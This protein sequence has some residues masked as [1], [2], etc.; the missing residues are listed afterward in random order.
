MQLKP[1]TGSEMF[2]LHLVPS[3]VNFILWKQGTLRFWVLQTLNY[4]VTSIMSFFVCYL[5]NANC[6]VCQDHVSPRTGTHPSINNNVYCFRKYL[7]HWR[8]Q[9]L[10]LLGKG[11]ASSCQNVSQV[12]TKVLQEN[13]N[14]GIVFTKCFLWAAEN[15][16]S[17]C[18]K[19]P[20][21]EFKHHHYCQNVSDGYLT[22]I[23]PL[24]TMC[25]IPFLL[26][27]IVT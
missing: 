13:V 2:T 26:K 20:V 22:K 3:A 10:G 21:M 4:T 8:S 1:Q 18:T 23:L 6:T 5:S 12:C 15:G 16:C 25:Y 7:C 17:S 24:P 27:G 9:S 19:F 14:I 11:T